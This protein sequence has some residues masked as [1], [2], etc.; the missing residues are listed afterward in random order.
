M[1][2]AVIGPASELYPLSF[3]RFFA[4]FFVRLDEV[5]HEVKGKLVFVRVGLSSCILPQTALHTAV[6][7]YG[8]R[9][10]MASE[11]GWK[12]RVICGGQWE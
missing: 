12:I 5:F 10:E 11:E 4:Q 2:A 7:I 8:L 6:V 3:K 1:L 9:L